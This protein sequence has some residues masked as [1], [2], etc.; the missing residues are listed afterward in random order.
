MLYRMVFE[1]SPGSRVIDGPAWRTSGAGPILPAPVVRFA[2]DEMGARGA[3]GVE[4]FSG[5]PLTI[6]TRGMYVPAA[7]QSHGVWKAGT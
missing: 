4:V 5:R 6:D 2:V 1:G 3:A 7:W